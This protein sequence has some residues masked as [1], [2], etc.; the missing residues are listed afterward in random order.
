MVINLHFTDKCNFHCKH[1]FVNKQ[2]RE[3][4]LEQ[5][6]IIVDKIYDY[7][8]AT[9]EYI[10]I[11][12]AGG[13]PL[14]SKNIQEIIDYI[15]F[16]NLDVSLITNGYYLSEDFILRNKHKLSMIGI[17][18][19]SLNYDTNILIGR[20]N[21]N[22]VI[23][24]EKL[25]SIC[26]VINSAKIK[27]KINTCFSK[28]N[29]D[30]KELYAFIKS[31][32]PD[33]LKFFRVMCNHDNEL[34]SIELSDEEWKNIKLK[35]KDFKPVF[36]DNYYMQ[37]SYIIVDS[38]GNLSKNNLHEINNSLLENTFKECLKKIK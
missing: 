27:L 32:N 16:K 22:Q 4:S 17:S 18:V 10:R 12:L 26:N 31:V 23:D 3:L 29:K 24:K 36:E 33:R 7:K 20:C 5:I 8:I 37:N 11:N 38:R 9:G 34:K 30:G 25:V 35:Y 19:D 21:G 28:V 2:N 6:K 14:L 13:E 15:N 1:C